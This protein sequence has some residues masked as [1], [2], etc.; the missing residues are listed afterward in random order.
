M[1]SLTW[2]LL[3]RHPGQ[4]LLEITLDKS[5]NGGDNK[6]RAT[7]HGATYTRHDGD[8]GNNGDGNKNTDG[9]DNKCESPL[10]VTHQ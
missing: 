1:K 4:K 7:N 2:M 5:Q 3:G 8:G 6:Q 10:D 9:D